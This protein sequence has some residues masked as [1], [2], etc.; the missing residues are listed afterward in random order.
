MAWITI[1]IWHSSFFLLLFWKYP[2]PR[3]IVLKT[4]SAS[5]HTPLHFY[6]PAFHISLWTLCVCAN[7]FSCVQ[8]FAILWTIARQVPLSMGFSRQEYYSGFPCLPPGA[9]PDPGIEPFFC[10]AR[11]SL[12]LSPQGNPTLDTIPHL[13]LVIRAFVALR[14]LFLCLELPSLH[15]GFLFVWFMSVPPWNSS[16]LFRQDLVLPENSLYPHLCHRLCHTFFFFWFMLLLLFFTF[17]FFFCIFLLACTL[18]K[19]MCL[20]SITVPSS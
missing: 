10:I 2:T 20:A 15:R 17:F 19:G 8:L 13:I 7:C 1:I 5:T 3:V 18:I 14:I 11:D 9:L 6:L 16:Q 12:P 4:Q